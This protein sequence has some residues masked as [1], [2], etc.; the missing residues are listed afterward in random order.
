MCEIT[1]L[2]CTVWETAGKTDKVK[3]EALRL[4]GCYIEKIPLLIFC[5]IRIIYSQA[6]RRGVGSRTLKHSK[7]IG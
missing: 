1:F 7:G 3:P 5:S 2:L 6:R 4:G